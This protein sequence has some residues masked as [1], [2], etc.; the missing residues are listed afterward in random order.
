MKGKK[1]KFKK[2][3]SR[4]R[5]KIKQNTTWQEIQTFGKS[6]ILTN[7]SRPD[8][9]KV[10][11]ATGSARELTT[12]FQV[13]LSRNQRQRSSSPWPSDYFARSEV[14]TA[15]SVYDS[16]L[17][18]SGFGGQEVACWLLVPKFAGSHPA[19][20]VGFFGRKNPQHAFLRRGSKANG[21]MS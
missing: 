4:P 7:T 16:S 10:Q 17:P 18:W 8:Y 9:N 6:P 11:A 1:Q 3:S 21:P 2:N 12:T 15:A 19:E 20:A 13:Y 5:M 14:L